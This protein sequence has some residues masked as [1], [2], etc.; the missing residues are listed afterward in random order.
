MQ[1]GKNNKVI[2]ILFDVLLFTSTNDFSDIYLLDD[3][4]NTL[5]CRERQKLLE[6]CFT[7]FF[8][9]KIVIMTTQRREVL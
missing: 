9:N 2:S 8:P 6:K 4:L 7:N 5:D 3:P 1:I